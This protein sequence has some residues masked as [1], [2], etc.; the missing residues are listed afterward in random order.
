MHAIIRVV[1]R[2]DA[3][4]AIGAGH[5]V[6]CLALAGVLRNRGAEVEFVCREMA[7]GLI[8]LV[9]AEGYRVHRLPPETDT[10]GDDDPARATWLGAS[11]EKDVDGTRLAIASGVRPAW[12]VVDHYALDERWESALRSAVER[13]AIIDDMADR[14]HDCDFLIDQNLG[15]EDKG[16]EGLVGS[17]C[18]L[19][20]GPTFALLRPE[21][22]AAR[23]EQRK[24]DGAMR[25]LL[26]SFGG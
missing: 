14:R 10:P 7:G 4:L 6:R 18:R 22:A 19:L 8:D 11:V 13:V 26:V 12:L 16:Y 25:R 5:L 20:L 3:S 2:V 23:R 17:D 21:F 9:A 1:F 24:R 15:A